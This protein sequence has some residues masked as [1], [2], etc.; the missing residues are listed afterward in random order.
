[1]TSVLHTVDFE[2]V[3]KRVAVPR[4]ASL[5]DAAR[6]AGLLLTGD[7]GGGGTC[8]QCEVIARDAD[9]AL[10]A[11]KLTE[12]G[13]LAPAQRAAG[14]RLACQAEVLG[15]V[16]VD[17]PQTS[18]AA[19][20]RLQTGS[21]L[22]RLATNSPALDDMPIRAIE[23][24]VE[25]ASLTD[26]RADLER[27]LEPLSR[28]PGVPPGLTA[29]PAAIRTLSAT[30]R[31]SGWRVGALVRGA[32]VIGF[33]P[34]GAHPLGLAVDLGTTKIAAYLVD[35]VTG[36]TLGAEG[37]SNPQIGYGEDLISRLGYAYSRPDGARTLA[38][39]V[40]AVLAELSGALAASAGLPVRHIVEA[41]IAGN[42]AMVHLLLELPVRQL[43]Q[44]PYMPAV[45][46]SQEIAAREL[47]LPFLGD[48]RV[49]VPPCVAGY[50][51]ADHVAMV[52][53]AGLDRGDRTALGIDIGT[54]TEIVLAR[55]GSASMTS[56]S[57]ASGPA[58]EGAHIQAG[59]RAAPGAIER[60]TIEDVRPI[61]ATIDGLPAVGICGSG[62]V[63]AI[64]ELRRAGLLNSRGRFLAGGP[65]V[66]EG[67]TG[68]EF[69]LVGA[70][71]SGTGEDIVI[72]QRDV[73]EIQMAKGAIQAGIAVLLESQGLAP[74]DLDEVVLA[75]AFGTY[76][77]LS[78][79]VVIGL[80]PKLPLDRFSQIGN[81]AGEGARQILLSRAAR[82]RA[83]DIARRISYI[84]LTVY[85]NFRRHYA[86]ALRL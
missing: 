10:S 76:L 69:V 36:E 57:C 20:Q 71:E 15:D 1:M 48:A 66:R 47:G 44:A 33:L 17:V 32:D 54:N 82:E 50:V 49:H 16:K 74:E 2:P 26:T 62:I 5:L 51:G 46:G 34:P 55:R 79:A 68:Q 64:A 37:R 65:G 53:A 24:T 35:L 11:P 43:A 12:E 21:S 28:Q 8:G 4:G 14:Y 80:L 60:L 41:C 13:V 39:A 38:Q 29:A 23:A 9:H 19:G 86:Q 70:A 6:Q 84:E 42:T 77:N 72:T 75:G 73:D 31:G 45:S 22:T 58:F 3:G 67:R 85:P 52:L 7:C 30:L 18:L 61:V 25:P 78:S 81:A 59:M 27:V 63:D 56:L 83:R 40:H